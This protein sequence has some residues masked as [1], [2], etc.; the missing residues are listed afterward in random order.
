MKCGSGTCGGLWRTSVGGGE[1]LS[2]T[3]AAQL[4]VQ[5]ISALPALILLGLVTLMKQ[6]QKDFFPLP[7]SLFYLCCNV[8]TKLL[9]FYREKSFFLCNLYQMNSSHHQN[10]LE[11]NQFCK[12]NRLLSLS[13]QWHPAE[14]TSATAKRAGKAA[15]FNFQLKNTNN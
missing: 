5:L 6:T 12:L 10:K 4:D 1:S 11:S 9:L 2:E 8:S 15:D 7:L 3:Q 14:V 13:G